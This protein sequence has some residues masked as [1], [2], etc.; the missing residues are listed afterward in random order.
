M[1]FSSFLLIVYLLVFNYSN[2][3]DIIKTNSGDITIQPITH[4]TLV[5]TYKSK[6]IYID[7]YGGADGFIGVANPDI[8]LITDIH[9][10]HLN[11][12]TLNG[13]DTKKTQFIIPQ[14][15]ADK[16]TESYKN[17]ITILTNGQSIHRSGLYISAIPMYNLPESPDAKHIRGRGNGYIINMGDKNI[18]ISGD[19]EDIVE[20]RNLKDIDAAFVCM[21]LPYT[22]DVNQAASAVLEF[23]PKIVYPYHYKGRPNF[24]DIEKFKSLVNAGDDKIEVRIRDWYKN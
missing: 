24:T 6:T 23:K 21:N 16:M 5:L 3:Q 11:I 12:E 18:Y 8:I 2:A 10:D 14:A 19:T 1:K 13:L 17:Q 22:M 15:V 20:M 4:G 9:G 7:P